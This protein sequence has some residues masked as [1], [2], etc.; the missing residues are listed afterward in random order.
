MLSW[1]QDRDLGL[2][3][4]DHGL[5]ITTLTDVYIKMVFSSEDCILIKSLKSQGSSVEI[6]YPGGEVQ[7]TYIVLCQEFV[8]YII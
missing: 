7:N 8:I 4:R 6:A 5:E 1:D 3:V 2:Q